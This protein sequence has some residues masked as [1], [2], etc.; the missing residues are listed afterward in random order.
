MR[1][2]DAIRFYLNFTNI[3]SGNISITLDPL[4]AISETNE[5][6]NYATTRISG[7]DNST[8]DNYDEDDEAN[9]EITLM[10]VGRISGNRFTEDGEIDDNDEAGVRFIV[11]NTGG[12]NT[13]SWRFEIKNLPYED[14]NDYR[15]NRQNS[16]RPGEQREYTLGFDN[17]DDGNYNIIVEVDSDDDVDEEDERDNDENDRLE[18]E[19]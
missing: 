19:N 15:S 4:N 12:E 6:N 10:E 2:G 18:V 9:L 14:D 8:D 13:G 7:T 16:L 1:P 17:P 3:K 11:K 5:S